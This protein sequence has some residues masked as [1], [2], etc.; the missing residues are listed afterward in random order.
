M[1]DEFGNGLQYTK[2]GAMFWL[3]ASNTVYFFTGDSVYA[4]VQDKPHLLDGSGAPV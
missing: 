2:K 1:Y 3:K 4:Y